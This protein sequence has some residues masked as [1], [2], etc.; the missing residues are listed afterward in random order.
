MIAALYIYTKS[1]EGKKRII[2]EKQPPRLSLN[3]A[4]SIS[5]WLFESKIE[6]L[7]LSFYILMDSRPMDSDVYRT[8]SSYYKVDL[9]L[10]PI[11]GFL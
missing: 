2:I 4:V 1:I 11:L 8:Y 6:I 10:N 7:I 3:F 5:F 9:Y